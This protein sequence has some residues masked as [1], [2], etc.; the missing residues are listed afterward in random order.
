M[1][2]QGTDRRAEYQ[3]LTHSFG[4]LEPRQERGDQRRH[5]P[6]RSVRRRQDAERARRLGLGRGAPAR[7]RHDQYVHPHPLLTAPHTHILTIQPRSQPNIHLRPRGP[8]HAPSR[9]GRLRRVL[10][11]PLHL[12]PHHASRSA[13]PQRGLY[14]R[15]RRRPG[16]YRRFGQHR[17]R[18]ARCAEARDPGL[19]AR[20]GGALSFRAVQ[21]GAARGR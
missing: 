6:R 1:S 18:G 16:T 13:P 12:Q 19:A 5:R 10:D 11:E 17:H 8:A 14:R 9:A 4:R 3:R 15:T 21:E 20:A 7:R 2:A